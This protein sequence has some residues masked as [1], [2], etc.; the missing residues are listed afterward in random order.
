M[1]WRSAS[2]ARA[3]PGS[4]T[5][6]AVNVLYGAP[7]GLTA[8]G[9]DLW[10]QDTRGVKGIAGHDHR[11]GAALA[12]GDLSRN[13]RDELAIGIPGGTISGHRR[14]G[15]VSVLYGRADGLSAVDDLWSQDARGIRGVAAPDD[16][17]GASL[18]IGDFDGD[19]AG[20]LAIGVLSE[21]VDG[22][23]GA[24]AVHVLRGSGT[25]LRSGGDELWTQSSGGSRPARR[26]ARRSVLAGRRGLLGR[27][28]R[29]PRRRRARRVRRR[30]HGRGRRHRAAR[31]ARSRAAGARHPP[32]GRRPAPASPASPRPVTASG[33]AL[34]SGD[35]RT[36]TAS[37]SW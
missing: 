4:R 14:A 24:G 26:S 15:A 1:I 23:F 27:R 13:G 5:P 34:A 28:D 10:T 11:F 9:S 8:S 35:L 7:G 30:R 37:P 2:P 16:R 17:F 22:A 12:A 21:T 32:P 6:G 18:A 25:G 29:R 19:G 36:A 33:R 20:D 31:P 3:S